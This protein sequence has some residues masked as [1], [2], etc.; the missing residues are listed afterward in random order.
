MYYY[1]VI[2]D[3]LMGEK[4]PKKIPKPDTTFFEITSQPTT[5]EPDNYFN[6]IL[7]ELFPCYGII[8]SATFV[9]DDNLF[10]IFVFLIM[11]ENKFKVLRSYIAPY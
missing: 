2:F 8:F 7:A 11:L 9:F 4:N 1:E 6:C 10:F 3:E 5:L